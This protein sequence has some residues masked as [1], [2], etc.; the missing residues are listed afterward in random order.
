MLYCLSM[1]YEHAINGN[2][3]YLFF[4]LIYS[5]FIRLIIRRKK[6]TKKKKKSFL[7]QS[8]INSSKKNKIFYEI[9][10]HPD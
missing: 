3:F 9:W 8:K 6:E 5:T 1:M 2:L 4:E 7:L 10:I